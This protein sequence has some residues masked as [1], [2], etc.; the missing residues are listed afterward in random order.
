MVREWEL[1]CWI[2]ENFRGEGKDDWGRLLQSH[3]LS[4]SER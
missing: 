1:G 4:S 3:G 2:F